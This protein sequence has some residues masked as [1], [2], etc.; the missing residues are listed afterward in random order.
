MFLFFL[1]GNRM[2]YFLFFLIQSKTTNIENRVKILPILYSSPPIRLQIFFRVSDNRVYCYN[3]FFS[4]SSYSLHL[5]HPGE[6]HSFRYPELRHGN[7][8][9]VINI[10]FFQG[11]E[12]FCQMQ[13][14]Q[15][16]CGDKF[17][18][19]EMPLVVVDHWR[20]LNQCLYSYIGCVSFFVTCRGVFRT[21]LNICDETCKNI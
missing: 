11:H 18:L 8:I 20:H 15:C 14:Q 12:K 5:L 1:Y 2:L 10:S 16:N 19:S 21:V 3:E 9:I 17:H 7:F 4:D 6:W 13:V